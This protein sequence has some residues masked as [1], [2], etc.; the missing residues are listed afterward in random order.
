MREQ[1]G[2][3]SVLS[4][5]AMYRE[6]QGR[7]FAAARRHSLWVI[8]LRNAIPAFCL[9]ALFA[10]GLF[11]FFNPFQKNVN[12]PAVSTVGVTGSK[13]T[14]QFPKLSGYKKDL[15]SYD[16][17]ADSAVQ[18][19]KKPTIM[20]LFSP[21]ARI[22]M[23]KDKYARISA[24]NG[25]YDS[26]TEK[27]QLVGQ[28]IM[29]TDA[30]YDVRMRDANIDLKQGNMETTNTV[31]VKM[32]NGSIAADSMEVLDSGKIIFFR[33]HVVSQFD[34]VDT[35]SSAKAGSEAEKGSEIRSETGK[36]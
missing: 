10:I 16:V 20:E 25:I 14:M 26:A 31:R 1:G 15:R 24:L 7:A 32:T 22:E 27:M 30:G 17:T 6:R 23:E 3:V 21:D 19:V 13:I 34:A 29:K 36:P 5:S 8:I 12:I 11:T 35:Q 2:S 33:G 4:D 9:I 28:V 18:E